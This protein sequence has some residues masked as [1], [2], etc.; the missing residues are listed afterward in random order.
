[1]RVS[2]TTADGQKHTA[3]VT[4]KGK[5]TYVER[6]R[7]IELWCSDDKLEVYH[8]T[9]IGNQGEYTNRRRIYPE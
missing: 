7:A 2:W 5:I 6:L 9:A 8:A 3:P 4:L 1:M